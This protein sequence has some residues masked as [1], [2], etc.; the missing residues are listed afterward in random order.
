[1]N[2]ISFCFLLIV[3]NV[4]MVS[5]VVDLTAVGLADVFTQHGNVNEGIELDPSLPFPTIEE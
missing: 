1:M 5:D 2:E 4:F 3:Q